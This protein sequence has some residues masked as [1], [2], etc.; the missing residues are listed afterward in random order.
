M[1]SLLNP[2]ILN[3]ITDISEHFVALLHKWGSLPVCSHIWLKATLKWFLLYVPQMY[4]CGAI[5]C[6]KYLM[7]VSIRQ[8]DFAGALQDINIFQNTFHKNGTNEVS[9]PVYNA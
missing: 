4:V 3:Q 7:I 1:F 8:C 5:Q 9:L 2:S 6:Y